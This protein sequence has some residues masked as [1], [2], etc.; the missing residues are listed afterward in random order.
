MRKAARMIRK[1]HKV[2][3]TDGSERTVAVAQ[4]VTGAM[5]TLIEITFTDGTSIRRTPGAKM[6]VIR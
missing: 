5:G 1:N 6:D 2:S 3:L 4:E